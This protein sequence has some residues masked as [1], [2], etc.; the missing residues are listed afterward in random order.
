MVRVSAEAA[1]TL[2]SQVAAGGYGWA[3]SPAM[4]ANSMAEATGQRRGTD[5]IMAAASKK[6]LLVLDDT[7]DV[8][9]VRVPVDGSIRL[10]T[11]DETQQAA[12]E[13]LGQDRANDDLTLAA[14]FPG[15][16]WNV[17]WHSGGPQAVREAD[18]SVYLLLRRMV[19]LMALAVDVAQQA[20][21]TTNRY[22]R[23]AKRHKH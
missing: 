5:R 6:T 22:T 2:K 1:H 23:A 10:M 8:T 15:L 16:F 21:G 18:C 11:R 3:V 12:G 20:D 17:V 4:F 19:P 9:H 7:G 13:V 14:L